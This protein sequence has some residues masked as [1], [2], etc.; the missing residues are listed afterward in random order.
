MKNIEL[1]MMSLEYIE[2]H[3]SEDLRT[4]DIAAA[5]FCSR[6]TLEKLFS[7]VNGISMRS[8]V[9]RRRMVL[10]AKRLIQSPEISI[11]SVAVEFGYS[12]NEAFTRAFHEVWGVNPSKMRGGRFVEFFPRFT[13]PIQEGD[14]YVMN[15]KSVDISQLYD[16]FK[17]RSNCWFVLTDMVN[18]TAINEAS[19]KAGD[20]CI[21]EQM[22]RMV[23]SSG[24]E[25]VIF[26]IGG[27]EFCMLT[28]SES[29]DYANEI[30][31][32]IRA[33]NGRPVVCEGAEYP[34]SLHVVTARCD[35]SHLRYSELFSRLHIALRDGKGPDAV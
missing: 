17:E 34:L 11:L 33:L 22:N 14:P 24:E 7:H 25:D 35:S 32:K 28:A 1:L 29:E 9:M 10:A 6:S 21:L 30:A 3:I 5:C 12:S 19:R 27:D 13:E 15:R 2:Q 23:R 31:E 8:Y 20:L 4:A 18:L 26:R 16:L